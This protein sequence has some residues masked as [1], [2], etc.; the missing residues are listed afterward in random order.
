MTEATTYN[1][2]DKINSPADIRLLEIHE[3]KELCADIRQYMVDVISEIGGHFGGGLGT[4]EL[5]VALHRVFNTPKDLLVWDTGHQA[6]P[7]KIVTGRKEELKKIRQ[8]GGISGFLKRNE[9]EYDT[10]GAGHASTSI[11]AALGMAV[12]QR[13]NNSKKKVIAVI[14]DGAMTGGMAYEAMNNSGILKADLIVVLNDNNMSIAPNV[15]QISNYFT[16]IISHPEFN[17]LKGQVWDLTGKLDHFGDRLRKIAVRLESGIKA[18]ITPGMLFEALGFRYFG[19]VNGHNVNQLVKLFEQVKELKGPILIHAI[20]EKGKG[21]IPAEKDFQHLHAATPFNKETGKALKSPSSIP[22][23][24]K[25][26]GEALTELVNGN[27]KIV[28]ITAAMPDGTGLDVLREKFPQNY[29]DVG[30]A[31]EHAVTFAAGLATQGMI[32]VVA[33]YSTFLQRAFDHLIHDVALQ[34]LHV[35]FVLDRAGLVGADG[36]THHGA[37]DLTYLRLIPHLVIMAPKDEAELRNMLYT[38]TEYKEGPVALRY[39]RGSAIGV[40]LSESFE[41]IPTGKGERLTMG[42]DAAFLAVGSM[43]QFALKA[44]DELAKEGIHIEVINMRFIKPLDE[45][46]LDEVVQGDKKIITLEENSIVGGF[47]SGVTEY[48]SQKNFKN[49]ILRIGLPDEFVEHGTQAELYKLLGIDVAGII[50]KTKLF[51]DNK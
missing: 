4:V 32:P 38:A 6:Y 51:L 46:L 37:F 35:V 44:A 16:E 47:G 33:I 9:S 22:S 40:K 14:G 21:Y 42:N 31:E 1:I 24:T 13:Y 17:K 5:T 10:F 7:H 2:L 12:A 29:F 50:K 18:V 27:S 28:G 36:P 15:W 45:Q 39:P 25:I 20:T 19:P 8:F 26:F 43:V 11:S 41:K 49:D 34:H 30:I 48:L 23:Y 3:L